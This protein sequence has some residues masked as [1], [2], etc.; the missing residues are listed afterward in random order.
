MKIVE[1]AVAK[2][3]G[4]LIGEWSVVTAGI[5]TEEL[6]FV[7]DNSFVWTHGI[8][9]QVKSGTYA[10]GFPEDVLHQLVSPGRKEAISH[11]DITLVDR[12]GEEVIVAAK[13]MLENR[14]LLSLPDKEELFTKK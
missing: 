8:N 2:L 14:L 10:V 13:L 11:C 6:I 4:R 12:Q 7:A 1:A 3:T 9:R 5:T